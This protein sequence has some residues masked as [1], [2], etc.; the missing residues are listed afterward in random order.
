M[1][2]TLFNEDAHAPLLAKPSLACSA[3]SL[4]PDFSKEA[5][6][7]LRRLF[8]KLW[9]STTSIVPSYLVGVLFALLLV[10]IQEPIPIVFDRLGRSLN[11]RGDDDLHG[12][13][14][15]FHELS[16]TQGVSHGSK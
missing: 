9:S 3:F 10:R 13:V 11:K 2:V 12:T 1:L 5:S 16:K 7:S 14:L 8:R 6:I 15:A 4:P